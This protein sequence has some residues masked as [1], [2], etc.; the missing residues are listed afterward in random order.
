[1][2]CDTSRG[3]NWLRCKDWLGRDNGIVNEGDGDQMNYEIKSLSFSEHV[4][5]YKTSC[6]KN[7]ITKVFFYFLMYLSRIF[8]NYVKWLCFKS[9]QAISNDSNG[10]YKIFVLHMI[11]RSKLYL[12]MNLNLF[13]FLP[14][15]THIFSKISLVHNQTECCK[16]HFVSVKQK[17]FRF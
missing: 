17:N 9:S 15:T 1:M 4:H 6:V 10:T 2:N 13:L 14:L 8:L 3:W 11:Q 7:I 12:I 16:W 5:K